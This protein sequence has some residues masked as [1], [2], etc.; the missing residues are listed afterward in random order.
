MIKLLVILCPFISNSDRDNDGWG[1]EIH[2]LLDDQWENSS[3]ERFILLDG[4]YQY[5]LLH[6][7]KG[8]STKIPF[9]AH[10]VKETYILFL[11][12]Q[13]MPCQ[14]GR[15]N[16][17]TFQ[18]GFSVTWCS[19]WQNRVLLDHAAIWRCSSAAY[20]FTTPLS[21]SFHSMWVANTI[22]LRVLAYHAGRVVDIVWCFGVVSCTFRPVNKGCLH[23]SSSVSGSEAKLKKFPCGHTIAGN[24]HCTRND[25]PWTRGFIS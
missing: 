23:F 15:K 9:P 18:L 21:S 4:T 2:F 22:V 20:P 19:G 5:S 3:M 12:Q 17:W 16:I 14:L 8:T 25:G 10:T 24:L 13:S 7:V 11:D 1:D 6:M